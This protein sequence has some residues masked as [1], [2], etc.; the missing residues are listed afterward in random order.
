MIKV[1]IRIVNVLLSTINIPH[2]PLLHL[3]QSFYNIKLEV[4]HRGGWNKSILANVNDELLIK[5]F[6]WWFFF[7]W[8]GERR[9]HLFSCF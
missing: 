9:F 5:M 1:Y 2:S 8:D 6:D 7:C 4:K 3:V